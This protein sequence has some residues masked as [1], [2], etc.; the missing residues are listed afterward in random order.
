MI[1]QQRWHL[2]V[3]QLIL[4]LDKVGVRNQSQSFEVSGTSV[5]ME[6]L[7]SANASLELID[8]AIDQ[9]SLF[10]SSFECC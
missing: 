2:M 3:K 6:T 7:G 5:S 8:N 9:V 1:L 4:I 10:R